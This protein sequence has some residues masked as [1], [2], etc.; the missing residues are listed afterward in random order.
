MYDIYI[1]IL[2]SSGRPFGVASIH[3]HTRYQL[4]GTSCLVPGIK[5]SWYL[6][7]SRSFDEWAE[8]SISHLHLLTKAAEEGRAEGA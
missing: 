1:Y 5:F 6:W 4:C 2:E 7:V 8:D 3:S